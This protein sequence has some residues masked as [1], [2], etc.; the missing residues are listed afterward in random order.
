MSDAA[1]ITVVIF[2]GLFLIVIVRLGKLAEKRG[3]E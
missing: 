3:G 2:V 1:F